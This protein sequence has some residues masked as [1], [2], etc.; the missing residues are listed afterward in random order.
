MAKV[1]DG[2]VVMAIWGRY[3]IGIV[4]SAEYNDTRFGK[5]EGIVGGQDGARWSVIKCGAWGEAGSRR[6]M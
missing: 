3:W 6:S 2:V 1:W 5:H 4:T